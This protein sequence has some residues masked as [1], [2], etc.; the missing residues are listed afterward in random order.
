MPY[1]HCPYCHE[2]HSNASND[3]C[4]VKWKSEGKP[5]CYINHDTR[6]PEQKKAQLF[7]IVSVGI[8]IMV[9][10]L[11]FGSKLINKF[12]WGTKQ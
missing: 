7:F 11:Y 4:T 9:L 1:H 5:T 6:T 10:W 8:I 3:H 2:T 12:F